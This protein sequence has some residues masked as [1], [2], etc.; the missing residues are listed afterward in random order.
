MKKLLI[1][2][3][4]FVS[5]H[6]SAQTISSESQT[7]L[8]SNLSYL[9]SLDMG[10]NH[11]FIEDNEFI[12]LE[13]DSWSVLA[14]TYNIFEFDVDD[15]IVI[16]GVIHYD[17]ISKVLSDGEFTHTRLISCGRIEIPNP[18]FSCVLFNSDEFGWVLRIVV[19]SPGNC[20]I[21]TNK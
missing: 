3:L 11:R 13:Y 5:A 21:K 8:L 10:L 9:D 4:L 6:M 14:I 15:D 18:I 2:L 7:F 12:D 17:D 16:N 1:C 19:F 20:L